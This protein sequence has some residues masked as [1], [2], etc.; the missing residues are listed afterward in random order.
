[1]QNTTLTLRF[2][3]VGKVNSEKFGTFQ[4]KT[5]NCY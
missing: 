4:T 1:M 2:E 5:G 3:N